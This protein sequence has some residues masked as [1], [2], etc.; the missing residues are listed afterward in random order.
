[1]SEPLELPA[2]FVEMN[3]RERGDV[4]VPWL[5]RLPDLIRECERRWSLTTFAPFPQLSYN[6]ASPGLMPDGT[7]MVLK[8]GIP[9]LDYTN[10]VQATRLYNGEGAVKLIDFDLEWGVQLLEHIKP[11]AMLL[12]LEDDAEATSIAAQLMRRLRPPVPA[13]HTFPTVEEW[14]EGIVALRECMNSGSCPFPERLVDVAEQLYAELLPSQAERVVLHGDLHHYNI[15]SAEREPWLAI[16]PHGVVGEPAYE[17]GAIVRNPLH[18][19]TFPSLDR[20]LRRRIDQ[21]AD[22][23]GFSRERIYGWSVATAVLSAWWTY[24]G[25][26]GKVDRA[27]YDFLGLVEV[28]AGLKLGS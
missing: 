4:G 26:Q 19:H 11:G 23:L 5:A 10:E 6:Y 25:T 13:E 14:A 7:P 21:L 17:V 28:L 12:R 1:M 15:L 27:F 3:T 24:E 22:E 16:D 8:I 9:G 2:Y 18:L 20:V